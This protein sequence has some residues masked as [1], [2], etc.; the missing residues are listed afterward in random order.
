MEDWTLVYTSNKS[1]EIAYLKEVLDENNI[2][3][4]IINKQD[5]MYLLG[6]IEL[7]VPVDQAFNASQIINKFK[8]E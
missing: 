7:Y 4:V 8:S 5:S 1:H 2:V 6:D 3:A